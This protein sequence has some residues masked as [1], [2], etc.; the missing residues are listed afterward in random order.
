MAAPAKK[1]AAPRY[2][3]M[4]TVLEDEAVFDMTERERGWF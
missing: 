4:R 3:R 1:Q 2:R